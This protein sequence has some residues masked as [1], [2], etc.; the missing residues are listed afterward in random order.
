MPDAAAAAA[1]ALAV[2]AGGGASCSTVV[3]L[4]PEEIDQATQK[5]ADY[6][7]PGA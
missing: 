6:R 7:P 5:T 3:L 4:E 2:S 1:A